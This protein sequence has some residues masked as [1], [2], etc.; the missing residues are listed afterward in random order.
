MP[1][2]WA[3]FELPELRKQ[4]GVLWHDCEKEKWLC[5][6]HL[7]ENDVH[8]CASKCFLTSAD[9]LLPSA[10]A[11]SPMLS[12][13]GRH[14]IATEPG[15][16]PASSLACFPRASP[17][18]R[19]ASAASPKQVLRCKG[20]T[21]VPNAPHTSPKP[22]THLG[23][24]ALPCLLWATACIGAQYTLQCGVARA[25]ACCCQRAGPCPATLPLLSLRGSKV[26]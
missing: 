4:N 8:V 21:T 1:S 22:V 12:C 15:L 20:L 25:L 3:F 19:R 24:K 2:R 13:S 17:I 18:P 23:N 5:T 11:V 16:S 26:C 14:P 6:S 9:S 7:K 10:E